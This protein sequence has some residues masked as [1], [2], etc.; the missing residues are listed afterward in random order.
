MTVTKEFV[1]IRADDGLVL[2]AFW[3]SPASPAVAI[4]H[5]HGKGGNFYH[6]QFLREM[7]ASMPS[8][9]IAILGLNTRGNGAIVEADRLGEVTYVGSAAERLS[10][11]ARDIQAAIAFVEQ[12]SPSVVLQG[13]SYGCDKVMF[14]AR[15]GCHLPLVL[16]SPADTMALFGKY[17]S[18][19]RD[20]PPVTGTGNSRNLDSVVQ[21]LGVKTDRREYAVPVDSRT[22]S[23]A[24]CGDDFRIFDLSMPPS[25]SVSNRAIALI[26]GN[27]DLQLGQQAAMAERCRE[28]LPCA[29]VEVL[30]GASHW[31]AGSEEW[32]AKQIASWV[33]DLVAS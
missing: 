25:M 31:F 1:S 7:Y 18:T 12:E 17:N 30:E 20:L 5:I 32:L 9:G 2:D 21:T 13:H 14:A 8:V 22:L 27:D 15:E 28:M 19:W 3:V 11:S 23:D 24:I 10:D 16:I 26:G 29:D 6:N 33:L 4:I